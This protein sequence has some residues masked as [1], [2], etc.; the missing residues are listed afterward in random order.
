MFNYLTIEIGPCN[1]KCQIVGH[2]ELQETIAI[3]RLL[4]QRFQDGCV[5][6]E[7]RQIDHSNFDLNKFVGQLAVPPLCDYKFACLDV[8][9]EPIAEGTKAV[10]CFEGFYHFLQRTRDVSISNLKMISEKPIEHSSFKSASLDSVLL[11]DC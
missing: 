1:N 11:N 2:D 7:L 9:L 6:L 3:L 5:T 4:P 8:M 10:D